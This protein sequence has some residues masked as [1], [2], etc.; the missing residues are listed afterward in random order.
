[1]V[2]TGL[3]CFQQGKLNH[4]SLLFSQYSSK[5]LFRYSILGD[6]TKHPTMA[7]PDNNRER[8]ED[9]ELRGGERQSTV[10]NDLP[11]H[12]GDRQR[13]EPEETVINLPDVSDIPG[14]ENVTVPRM[15]SFMDTTISSADEE[16]DYL[17]SADNEVGN[18]DRGFSDENAHTAMGQ[19]E[20]TSSKGDGNTVEGTP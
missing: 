1:M 5:R 10:P 17:F 8:T 3:T 15:E 6:Y 20:P 19:D 18:G 12:A 11:E 7:T 2:V 4:S 16:G 14:Q 9:M 13:L